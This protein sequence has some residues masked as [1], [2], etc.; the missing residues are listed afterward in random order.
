[1]PE[2]GGVVPIDSRKV[3]A[4]S[5]LNKHKKKDETIKKKLPQ[6]YRIILKQK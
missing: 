1:V 4:K 5:V 3:P 2:G 6:N